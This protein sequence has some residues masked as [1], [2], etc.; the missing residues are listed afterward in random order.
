MGT[1][2]TS[3]GRSH[4]TTAALAFAS[5]V[6]GLAVPSRISGCRSGSSGDRTSSHCITVFS[7]SCRGAVLGSGGEVSLLGQAH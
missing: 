4:R 3:F 1:R 6:S 7:G 2:A 5:T